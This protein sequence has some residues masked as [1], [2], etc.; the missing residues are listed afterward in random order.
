MPVHP[1]PFGG[2]RGGE[3]GAGAAVAPSSS[4]PPSWVTIATAS[5]PASSSSSSLALLLLSIIRSSSSSSPGSS[6]SPA[7]E[8][9]AS[10]LPSPTC[11]VTP[12][13]HRH[14]PRCSPTGAGIGER[15][16]RE[17]HCRGIPDNPGK[18]HGAACKVPVIAVVCACCVFACECLLLVFPALPFQQ[19]G[20][21]NSRQACFLARGSRLCH[22]VP[23]RLL[24]PD[25]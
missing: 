11:T 25:V 24:H 16:L 12:P 21:D 18:S 8:A 7:A 22:T 3:L 5:P 10:R 15:E 20:D 23:L 2:C 17:V 6:Q 1:G 19:Q 9:A 13:Q 4:A 14:R